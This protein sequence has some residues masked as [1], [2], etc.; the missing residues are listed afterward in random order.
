MAEEEK[1]EISPQLIF[2]LV[3]KKLQRKNISFILK[4]NRI[5]PKQV[6]AWEN[7]LL[8]RGPE[9]F[10]KAVEEEAEEEQ[11]STA[12]GTV[13]IKKV[14]KGHAGHHGGA[15]KVAYA[16]FVTAMMAFFLLMWL[17]SMTDEAQKLG[18]T[19]YFEKYSM[20]K[21]YG[22]TDKGGKEDK[23]DIGLP[24]KKQ[25]DIEVNEDP[26]NKM[27]EALQID[28]KRQFGSMPDQV[29]M[30]FTTDGFR[31]QLVD[32]YDAPMFDS[33]S[34]RLK[35]WPRELIKIVAKSIENMQVR[36]GIEG[37]TDS[38]PYNKDGITN[39][40]L[41]ALRAA[42]RSEFEKNGI[43]SS[44]FAKIVGYADTRPLIEEDPTDP[45]NRRIA[46]TM[47]R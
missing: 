23:T 12:A 1:T 42:A 36:I 14:K 47:L 5:E 28:I 44:R 16:D 2:N 17:V 29:Q 41:S 24:Q 32:K 10:E 15:W 39:W 33:G 7:K 27:T 6:Q 37:Y 26:Y 25:A 18:I 9:I 43:V 21:N 22:A 20:F 19:E 40:E 46:I 11:E 31:I 35:P 13:I 38:V 4:Q 3:L 8:S 34:N 45:R 30:D